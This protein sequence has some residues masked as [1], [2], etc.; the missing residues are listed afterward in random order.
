MLWTAPEGLSANLIGAS[1]YL[2]H[3]ALLQWAG[4]V[5][6]PIGTYGQLHPHNSE[7]LLI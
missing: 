6:I 4:E 1:A 7:T 3:A 5:T 2:V